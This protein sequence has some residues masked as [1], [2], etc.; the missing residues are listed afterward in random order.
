MKLDNRR[1]DPRALRE[2]ANSDEMQDEAYALAKD[3]QRD[4]RRLAPVR[5]GNLRRN[6]QIEEITDLD[7]GIEGFAVGWGDKGWYGWM[8]ENGTEDTAAH[9]HLVPA[10]IRN[11]VVFRGSAL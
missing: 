4:A 6:I 2:I 8:E 1:T 7:S 10:A 9:P 11:G 3:V 5:S